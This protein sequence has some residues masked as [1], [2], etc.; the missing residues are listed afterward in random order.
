[1]EQKKGEIYQSAIEKI[2]SGDAFPR[3]ILTRFLKI[4]DQSLKNYTIT[5]KPKNVEK[6]YKQ[7]M[8]NKDFYSDLVNLATAILHT[9][10]D[11]S[12]LDVVVTTIGLI[13]LARHDTL[14]TSVNELIQVSGMNVI[15]F[16][17]PI[18]EIFPEINS[19][20]TPD[21]YFTDSDGHR[22][23]LELKVRNFRTDLSLFYNKY[24]NA[25]NGHLVNVSVFNVTPNGFIEMGDY[26]LTDMINIDPDMIS[27]VTYCIELCNQLR[28]KYGRYPEF[29]AYSRNNLV[30]DVSETFIDAGFEQMVKEHPDY[31]EIKNLFGRYWDDI[32]TNVK[33][34]SLIDNQDET[35]E[36][37]IDANKDLYQDCSDRYKYFIHHLECEYL[38]TDSYNRTALVKSNLQHKLDLKNKESYN[39]INKYKPAIYIPIAKTIVL[40]KYN[41]SRLE[42]YKDA[43]IGMSTDMDNYTSSVINLANSIFNS[44]AIDLL[45]K[46]NDEIDPDLYKDV[47]TPEFC[48][49]INDRS[50]RFNKIANVSNITSDT[51]ILNN[52]SF[53]ICHHLDK[54]M[55][56][57][58]NGF[59][60]KHYKAN[61]LKKDCL[62]ISE[63]QADLAE[64]EKLVS[65]I[66]HSKY[67]E[68]VYANDLVSVDHDNMNTHI[69]D[70]PK[71]CRTKFLDHLY[72]QH[73][74]FKA[75]ISLNTVNSHK[76]RFIQTADPC[77]VL[78]MLP[79]ADSLKSAPLR[80]FTLTI[81]DKSDNVSYKANKLLGVAH[82]LIHG[83]NYNII[84][85][86]VISLDVNRLKLLNHSFGKYCLIMSYYENLKK[87]IPVDIH[88][89]VWLL[90]QFVT[91]SSL[92]ITDTYKNFIMA[93]Y[94][95]Y[96]N[97]DNLID[98]KLESR[99]TTLG[100]VMVLQKC[101]DGINKAVRQLAIINRNKN[102]TDIDDRGD[103]IN[104]GFHHNLQ[105]NLPISGI[106]VNNPKE[107]I[108]E[109]FM[110]FY[111]GNKGL[112]GSPQELLKLYYV[113]FKFEKEYKEMLDRYDTVLQECGNDSNMSFSYEALKKTSLA[114]YANLYNKKDMVRQSIV[115]E[116]DFE[117]PML[118][119]KQFS[120]T[121]S[122]VSNSKVNLTPLPRRF[123][124][125]LDIY[126]LER[127]VTE[128]IIEDELEFMTFV[129]SEVYRINAK[130]LRDEANSNVM[131]EKK[132]VTLL[133]EIYIENIKGVRFVKIKRHAYTR[134]INGNYIK[135]NNAKV[136]DE[137]F[138]LTEEY[139]ISSLKDAY[140]NLIHDDDLLI[141]IFY[142]DQRTS[143]DRE[144]YTGN[145][146]TRLCLYPIEK[147]FKAVCKHI[148]GEAITISGDQKQ[149][150]LLEQRLSLLKEKRQKIKDHKDAEIYSVS[151][152][153]SKWSARDIFLKFIVVI[154]TMPYLHPDE[155]WFLIFLCFRYY[156][157][158]IV[159]TDSIFNSML[160][161]VNEDRD[162]TYEE[163]TKNFENNH[164]IVRSNWLQG[165]LNMISSFVHHC[166]TLYTETMLKIF[167][168]REKIESNM[169]SMVHSDDSTYDFLICTGTKKH[170]KTIRSRYA[171]KDNIGKII[172]ALITF[173]NKL[174]C[175]TL[176]EK[177]TY[178][179]TFYKE[180]LSTIIVGNE[181][182]FFYLADL[183]PLT[184]DTS[185]ASPMQDLASYSG[186]INNAFSHA[187]PLN[188]I[189]TAI[190]LINHLTLSTY[191][192]QYT[193]DKNPR[194]NIKSSDLPIQIYPR[195]KLPTALAG[196]I[197][198][199]SADAFNILNDILLKLEKNKLLTSA[200]IED[201]LTEESI[202]TYLKEVEKAS[203][204]VHKYLKSCILCMDYSQYERD[205]SDPYNIIDY[206]L[207]QKSIINVISL[208]KG[209]RLKKTK[210]YK[211]F[212][213]METDVRLKAAIHPEWCVQKPTDPEL[214]K[215]NILQ[216]YTNPN[217]RDGL[218]FSTPAIDYGRRII[219]SNKNMYTI[220]SHI[221]EKDQAKSI[222][223]VYSDLDS[224]IDQ[225]NLTAK[226]LQRYLNLYLLSDKKVLM[227]LQVYYSKEQVT[228]KEKPSYNKVIQPRS[229]Y[230][231][232]FGKYSNTK[233]IESLL[234]SRF[235]G[236]NTVDP[237][238]EKFIDVCEYVLTRIG[239]IKIYRD[240]E[241]IDDDYVSYFK[242]KYPDA[243]DINLDVE[244][245]DNLDEFGFKAYNNKI[246]F[247]SLLVRYFNDIKMTIENPKIL[248]YLTTH[249]HHLLSSI[250]SLLKKDEISSKVYLSN[251]KSTKYDDYLLTRYGMYAHNSHHVQ[252]RLNHKIRI[253]ASGRIGN[254][255]QV[256][257]DTHE[258]MAFATKLISRNLELFNRLR[259]SEEFV[260][261]HYNFN[262]MLNQIANTTEINNAAMLLMLNRINNPRF[263]RTVVADTRLY[264]YWPKP[265]NSDKDDPNLS[266]AYYMCKGNVMRVQTASHGDNVIFTMVYFRYQNKDYGALDTIKRKINSD[267]IDLLRKAICSNRIYPDEGHDVFNVKNM[268]DIHP[269]WM[270]KQKNVCPIFYNRLIHIEP[271]YTEIEN[272]VKLI[273]TMHTPEVLPLTFELR[274]RTYVDDEYYL[275]CLLDNIDIARNSILGYLCDTDLFHRYPDYLK[276]VLEDLGPNQM[277]SLMRHSTE[278]SSVTTNINVD[279]YGFIYQI[280]RFFHEN[281]NEYMG[282]VCETLQ[283]VAIQNNVDLSIS[284]NPERFI[285]GC[286]KIKLT[287]IC[288]E[289]IVQ[290]YRADEEMPYQRLF[291]TV[292]KYPFHTS[293]VEK[294][295]LYIILV[296]KFYVHDYI[297]LDTEIEY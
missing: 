161:L 114:A 236:V 122:M 167:S 150:K 291:T 281:G 79:N 28:E 182:F 196:M 263:M 243:I 192:M 103:L 222:K 214:I 62:L 117:K 40:E 286:N 139:N 259:E 159:L 72:S 118:S 18:K 200:L 73:N 169:T 241:D 272:N 274:L 266:C 221:M 195:Y 23:I 260:T 33:K 206:D 74:I 231:E 120:S 39:I 146:Q 85:S 110:L 64:M 203:P 264:N 240:P 153:A 75:L 175:I 258:P 155:K 208:N 148:P 244:P 172:I 224:K 100:H 135:Q 86:K 9:P 58:I 50:T 127:I 295:I 248:T 147:T 247:L 20:L 164:F 66:F 141:R 68:G 129:N 184:S 275:N 65:E 128:S 257:K 168:E 209:I 111:L 2:R 24:K 226:D 194:L 185:Y 232:D 177:K 296:F 91:I 157:K 202:N 52:N 269:E 99:P 82:N 109:S 277:L 60:S 15:G 89:M 173:S 188:M 145:A 133:P 134:M 78:I 160:N 49:H 143:D 131:D 268:A 261:G 11:V 280:S 193:S 144:I 187:C 38:D 225:V 212:L 25:V 284:R 171:N 210:T 54:Y 180:F 242:F 199:Y 215:S 108:H 250:D 57:N 163:M 53:S 156:K 270:P 83:K 176:N 245:I 151:S 94:S 61:V 233:L 102:D 45:V 4:A 17:K 92:S 283:L 132:E 124:D 290:R 253:A 198:Y 140:R 12:Q 235:C 228:T 297:N 162:G 22:Y 80:Y 271:S 76:Y 8:I 3:D 97:I 93:I 29:A 273:L 197:P 255:L 84:L 119:L 238:V 174:H 201:V 106:V 47:L 282:N 279:Q 55:K 262:D 205:D 51:S 170:K 36:I 1:M 105:L 130:R 69:C 21:I 191:N 41:Y 237:K 42:F 190:I 149:K 96:S 152:D 229:V 88:I 249:P 293:P 287:T 10:P 207:S 5:S 246:K 223:A 7:C 178:I 137:F 285:N 227:A 56:D 267:Y 251:I 123:P 154:S 254:T 104:T 16:D 81:I 220:S 46:K 116:L 31:N 125:S 48:M 294:M 179:S 63:S 142:K 211:K 219:S 115:K 26:R 189:K 27:D 183:L 204:L 90:C 181:L 67:Y 165:N 101:F 6:I 230:A 126:G 252:Y 13:E 186:Y 107:I 113:P 14:L 158:N 37:L 216:N 44:V 70:L 59:Q 217:F 278:F 234:T 136:F 289:E 256:H 95:D 213:E 30:D 121:K 138:R 292:M 166:S 19:I 265:T 288:L 276:V 239:D 87:D 98:D 218:I 34:I 71:I 112:H 32:E 43:F 77:T 35:A